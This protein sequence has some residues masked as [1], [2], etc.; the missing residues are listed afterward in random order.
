M[1]EV[2]SL[3]KNFGNVG[4]VNKVSFKI[5]TPGI[6]VIMGPSGCGKTTLLRLLAGL[7]MPDEGEVFLSDNLVSKKDW[8][9]APHMRNMGFVF[10][11][12]AL[13]PH[14]TIRDNILFGIHDINEDEKEKRLK[15]ILDEMNI[16][17]IENRYPDEISGGQARRVALA[18]S[19]IINP[20][21]LLLDEPLTNV[22]I[23]LKD[24]LIEFIKET[25]VKTTP[26]IVYVTHDRKEAERISDRILL[27]EDGKIK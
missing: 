5:D 2:R 12:P 4:A 15:E 20:E 23:Q 11:A 14:M 27:M 19:V 22:D 16:D 24:K 1:I 6:T 9:V 21:Y 8:L 3:S 26:F 7:E 13:F 18:R 25:V 10:Q 17:G